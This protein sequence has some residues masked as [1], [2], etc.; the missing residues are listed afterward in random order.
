MFGSCRISEWEG[1]SGARF[2]EKLR[3]A[4]NESGST[5]CPVLP[6]TWMD[7]G[8][9]IV[10]AYTSINGGGASIHVVPLLVLP[11][12]WRRTRYGAPLEP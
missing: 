12:M 5:S 4:A 1:T 7:T 10:K 2:F 8:V 6:L 11:L 9:S 3:I